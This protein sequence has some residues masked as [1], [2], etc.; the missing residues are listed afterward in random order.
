M[1]FIEKNKGDKPVLLLDD[2][3]SELD[4]KHQEAVAKCIESNQT[5]LTSTS[6][7]GFLQ[8]KNLKIIKL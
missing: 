2:I 1:E 4:G 7:P 5:I 6:T 3:F 8:N